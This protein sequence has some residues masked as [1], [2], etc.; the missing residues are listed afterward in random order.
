MDCRVNC[1]TNKPKNRFTNLMHRVQ[2]EH[3]RC[4]MLL[5]N[6]VPLELSDVIVLQTLR[7]GE[8]RR[9]RAQF[10]SVS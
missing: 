7:G 5:L 8:E 4:L 6:M 10:N 1:L 9:F 2:A 3:S